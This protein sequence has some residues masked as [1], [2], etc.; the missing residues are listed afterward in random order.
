MNKTH[1]L[2][3]QI[4]NLIADTPEEIAEQLA[5]VLGKADATNW[6]IL[7]AKMIGAVPQPIA[8]ERVGR[9][10]DYWQQHC[11]EESPQSIRLALLSAAYTARQERERQR[12]EI[13]WTGPESQVVPVRRTDQA[14][15]EL[16]KGAQEDLHVVSFAVYHIQGITEALVRAAQRG[17]AVSI[18]LE[19][20]DASEG[21][22]AFN[23][24]GAL[25][26][27]LVQCARLYVWPL[28]KR[29]WS[30]DGHHGS[31][32]AKVAVADSQLM[33]VSSANLTEYA[34]K[35]NMELGLMVRGGDLPREI[36]MHLV[37]L[38]EKGIFQEV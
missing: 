37:R 1:Q 21:K 24:I 18:Y 30:E 16:I 17:V 22:I 28:E 15:L 2:V 14:L 34:M 25:G 3:Q 31:L 8:Q 5:L 10:M 4:H 26:T 11:P 29:L 6:G 33:L 9:F 7:R 19:T 27:E 36:R 38:V 12:L 35:L 20:P 13:V 23:T 32:H